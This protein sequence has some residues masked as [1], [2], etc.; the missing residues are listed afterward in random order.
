[1]F[2]WQANYY[3]TGAAGEHIVGDTTFCGTSALKYMS[4]IHWLAQQTRNARATNVGVKSQEK[5]M[6]NEAVEKSQE[7]KYGALG[8]I[9]PGRA[10]WRAGLAKQGRGGIWWQQLKEREA[11]AACWSCSRNLPPVSLLSENAQLPHCTSVRWNGEFL[12]K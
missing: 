9:W 7:L 2:W 3:D 11:A 8:R 12:T 10:R 1:M 6:L 4:T 5:N